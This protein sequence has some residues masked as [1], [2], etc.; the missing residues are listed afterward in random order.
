MEGDDLDVA[1]PDE[2]DDKGPTVTD[3]STKSKN[4]PWVAPRL[5]PEYYQAQVQELG[6]M[7]GT[8][9]IQLTEGDNRVLLDHT[10]HI[11]YLE[12]LTRFCVCVCVFC[13]V[14]FLLHCAEANRNWYGGTQLVSTQISSRQQVIKGVSM[15]SLFP[16]PVDHSELTFLQ[17]F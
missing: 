3:G 11:C 2:V 9:S 16:S 12:N 15:L 5:D 13:F 4:I 7:L 8:P 1:I 17:L 10:P 14:L 6:T